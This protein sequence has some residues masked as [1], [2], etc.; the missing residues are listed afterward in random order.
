MMFKQ[1]L[2]ILN[3]FTPMNKAFLIDGKYL[4]KFKA[5]PAI[6][7]LKDV[8][9]LEP[10][11]EKIIVENSEKQQR[12]INV[13]NALTQKMKET[14]SDDERNAYGEELKKLIKQAQQEKPVRAK[15][16]QLKC[17]ILRH[18]NSGYYEVEIVNMP[19]KWTQE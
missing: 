3:I 15:S 13:Y 10:K 2:I 5:V 8:L 17:R 18:D 4:V 14:T 19:K 11:S 1:Q 6:G 16:K 12:Y 9:V 7:A